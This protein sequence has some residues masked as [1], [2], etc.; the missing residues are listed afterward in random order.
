MKKIHL[1]KK[2]INR[3]VFVII[4]ILACIFGINK[5]LAGGYSNLS[6]EAPASGVVDKFTINVYKCSK[7]AIEELAGESI[8]D[9]LT[10]ANYCGTILSQ[11]LMDMSTFKV[12]DGD[13]IDPGTVV[14]I[15]VH[16]TYEGTGNSIMTGA[17]PRTYINSEQATWIDDG[18][19]KPYS[20]S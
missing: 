20:L 11:G 6:E 3:V 2:T 8:S 4:G 12:S 14:L 16:Y 18:N 9:D 10:L 1:Y 7:T 17:T 5:A 13:S 15:E 19:S